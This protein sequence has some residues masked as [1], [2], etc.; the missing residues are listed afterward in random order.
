MNMERLKWNAEPIVEA[1]TRLEEENK[2]LEESNDEFFEIVELFWD[3]MVGDTDEHKE[4]ERQDGLSEAEI[5]I[6]RSKEWL[7]AKEALVNFAQKPISPFNQNKKWAEWLANEH[8]KQCSEHERLISECAN[9]E[10]DK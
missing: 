4:V 9:R 1:M 7:R 3:A 10:D 2:F 6:N 8:K 5:K